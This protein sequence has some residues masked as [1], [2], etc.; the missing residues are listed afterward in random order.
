S[1]VL[2]VRART[3][4]NEP[5]SDKRALRWPKLPPTVA[6]GGQPSGPEESGGASS[7]CSAQH[8][9]APAQNA[10]QEV[11]G[12]LQRH[13]KQTGRASGDGSVGAGG[14][15][16]DVSVIWSIFGVSNT[17]VVSRVILVPAVTAADAGHVDGAPGLVLLAF[18]HAFHA[19]LSIAL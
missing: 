1:L 9:P 6:R 8:T 12:Q 2:S 16:N 18:G 19:W 14:D 17:V 15:L 5:C 10:I 13:L 4:A 3:S 7:Y 11:S